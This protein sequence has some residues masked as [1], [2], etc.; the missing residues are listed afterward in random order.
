MLSLDVGVVDEGSQ[1]FIC[2]CG[3]P[4]GILQPSYIYKFNTPV[5]HLYIHLS[6]LT[7][8]NRLS[9]SQRVVFI[10]QVVLSN[11]LARTVLHPKTTHYNDD[12][13]LANV[14]SIEINAEMTTS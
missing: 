7:W 13:L 2:L 9:S 5:L 4:E 11:I 12:A 6:F 8:H 1:L 3:C 10:R 14:F